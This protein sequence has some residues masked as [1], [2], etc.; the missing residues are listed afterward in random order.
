MKLLERVSMFAGGAV[1]VGVIVE[2]WP[3][4]LSSFTTPRLPHIDTVG[5][6][7][8]AI[9]VAVEV[10]MASRIARKAE[11]IQELADQEILKLNSEIVAAQERIASLNLARAKIEERLLRTIGP[12][13]LT[14]EQRERIASKIRLFLPTTSFTILVVATLNTEDM[15]EVTDFAW[16][17]HDVLST[18]DKDVPVCFIQN[19]LIVE[20]NDIWIR[21]P[22]TSDPRAL[23]GTARALFSILKEEKLKV[24][25]SVNVGLPLV[26]WKGERNGA[27]ASIATPD[28]MKDSIGILL[29]KRSQP[30]FRLD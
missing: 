11:S 6:V 21:L 9:G 7:I 23:E 29:G 22:L 8:V 2:V 26:M 15:T 16:Q 20:T 1:V 5:A 19:P 18:E 3:D 24:V 28:A 30:V 17:L 27:G 13:N 25:S 10:L 12:R 4:I 14:P